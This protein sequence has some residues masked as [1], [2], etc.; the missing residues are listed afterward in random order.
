VQQGDRFNNGPS[1][2]SIDQSSGAYSI[3]NSDPRPSSA[4][5]SL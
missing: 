4:R 2:Q 5:R 3:N 1:R